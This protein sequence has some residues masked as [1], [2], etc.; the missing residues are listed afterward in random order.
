MAPHAGLRFHKQKHS[1]NPFK[2]V[3][4][5]RHGIATHW[6]TSHTEFHTN[7]MYLRKTTEHKPVVDPDPV[8]W[9][10]DGRELNL[11]QECN[12]PFQAKGWVANREK[13][14]SE[15]MSKKQKKLLRNLFGNL[16]REGNLD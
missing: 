2:V 3:L 9:T 14:L 5:Q 11:F 10:R 4:R 1:S 13:R 12:E 16:P 15:P 8:V 6:S 7:V